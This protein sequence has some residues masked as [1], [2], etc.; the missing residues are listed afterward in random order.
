MLKYKVERK[1]RALWVCIEPKAG[2]RILYLDTLKTLAQKSDE[3]L[4][5]FLIKIHL[6]TT[7]NIETLTFDRVEILPPFV[8][9]ALRL[10]KQAECVSDVLE[11][12]VQ[13]PLVIHPRLVLTETGGCFANLWMDYEVE[14]IEY[15]DFSPTVQGRARLKKEEMS[16][17]KDLLEAGFTKKIVGNSHYFCPKDRVKEALTLLIEVGWQVI[18][19]FGKAVCLKIRVAEENGHIAISAQIKALIDH[20]LQ[21]EGEW[22]NDTLVLKRN[23]I[24]SL[25]SLLEGP[26]VEWNETLLKCAQ[27]LKNSASVESISVGKGFR[28]KLLPY[29]QKGVDWLYFLYKYGFSALLADE[30]GLGK[31]VQVLAFLSH[32][33]TNL[34]VLIVSP[35]SLL[36]NWRLEIE[37]FL[38]GRTVEIVSYAAL[39]LNGFCQKEY[40]VII[41]DESN[42]IKTASTQ[43][44]KA[45]CKLKGKF[46]ICISGTPMENRW[47]E[48]WSQFHFLMPNLVERKSD[49]L[50]A[51]VRPFILRRKKEDVQ[52]DL[53]E[54]IEQLIWVEMSEEQK[55]LYESFKKGTRQT[56]ILETIL[57]LRQIA[58]D[59]RLIE[60]SIFGAKIE[61]LLESVAEVVQERRKCLIFSSF[62]SFLRLIRKEL[63]NALYLDGEVIAAKREEIVQSFQE[64]P[65]CNVLLLSLKAGGVGL[66]LTA[67]DY[68]F[69][70]DPWWNEAVERQAID[71]AHRIGRK[72][73][74]IAKR[75]L[76]LG[77][78][79]EKM[80][81]LKVEKQKAAD[82][83]LDFEGGNFS[84]ND[85]LSLLT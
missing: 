18:D 38:P 4:V 44:A 58:N 10:L 5:A 12:P 31:T 40:E 80:L 15:S 1:G 19:P 21:M 41:L 14:V 72:N 35:A 26:K 43:T 55:V 7:R 64:N 49:A 48:I 16:F 37:K 66:N 25:L 2:K 6:K 65:D 36:F 17:E 67:A 69:L 74:V 9:E 63:P 13:K 57:R 53:P 8:P 83:L 56:S 85:L 27:G 84:E 3:D 54:K 28:G 79:E 11:K 78:V 29:Q 24:G 77:T 76:S 71:R 30:M 70:M 81:Q 45:A 75:F 62:T 52:I 51:Q 50:Q 46:K 23:K 20:R 42:A 47:D 61:V 73:T 39:R 34:P 82:Q 33:G 59:P 22:V 32:I 68:V 60:S